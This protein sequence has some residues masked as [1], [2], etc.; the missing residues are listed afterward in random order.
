MTDISTPIAGAGAAAYK[1]GRTLPAAP[2]TPAAPASETSAGA[3]GGFG[4]MVRESLQTAAQTLREG[5]AIGRKGLTGQ[6]DVQTVVEATMAME[7]TV[8]TVTA[9]RDKM[10]SAYQE[11][12]RMPV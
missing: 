10:V 9:V 7:Q 3:E 8:Q 1:A 2:V 4:G 12:V 11:I 5:E 6:A